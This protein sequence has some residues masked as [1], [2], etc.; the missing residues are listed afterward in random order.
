MEKKVTKKDM[1]KMIM[2]ETDNQEIIKFCQHEIELLE[3]KSSKS[4]QTKTQVENE[5]IKVVILESLAKV[6]KPV[7]ISELQELDSEM[8]QFSNQKLSALLRALKEEGKVVRTEDKKKARFSVS[9]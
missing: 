6:A 3:R 9:E 5:K 8:A 2:E 1:F 4:S 7:T